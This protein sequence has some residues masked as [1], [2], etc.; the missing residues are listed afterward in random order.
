MFLKSVEIFGFKSFAD[1]MTIDFRTGISAILGPNGCGKSNIVDAIKWVLG[2][3]RSKDVRAEKKEDVIFNGTETRKR[4]NVAEVTL[5]ISNEANLLPIDISEIS[6]KR[7]IYRSGENE[8][9]INGVLSRQRDVR[10]LF[11]DT[12]IGKSAYSILEQGKIDQVLSNKPEER[13]YLFEEA[14]GISKFKIKRLEA[15]RKLERT[16]ENIKQVDG[17]INEVKKSHDNLLKQAEKASQYRE[18]KE[19]I[20]NLELDLQLI[21]LKALLADKEDK[22][23]ALDSKLEEQ[24]TI[25]GQ[26]KELD[27]LRNQG[28]G[29]V[30]DMELSLSE[31][32]KQIFGL[33]VEKEATDQQIQIVKE[34]KISIE[35]QLAQK[36]HKDETFQAKLEEIREQIKE[37]EWILDEYE[38]KLKDFNQNI[39]EFQDN[40]EVSEE[41]IEDNRY[42]MADLNRRIRES[43]TMYSELTSELRQITDEI[44][45]QLDS[46]L[47]SAGYSKT[48]KEQSEETIKQVLN[49]I[50]T[51]LNNKNHLLN[52]FL[53][54]KDVSQDKSN[55]F[56]ADFKTILSEFSDNITSLKSA[57]N[58][59]V[60]IF[61]DFIDEFL[62]PE[63][64]ITKKR[65]ID[66]KMETLLETIDE[67]TV[68]IAEIEEENH[69][70]TL[71]VREY[72]NTLEELKTNSSQMRTQ[73]AGFSEQLKMLLQQKAAQ[74][75]D[76][77][78]NKKEIDEF[79]NKVDSLTEHI[80]TLVD[81][82][83][84]ICEKEES[85]KDQLDSVRAEIEKENSQISKNEQRLINLNLNSD[86]V[87]A[88]LEKLQMN[89]VSI[90][91]DIQNIYNN[92]REKHSR[93]LTEFIDKIDE[94]TATNEELR[95]ALASNREEL[96]G[97]G[98]VNLMAPQEYKEVKERYDFLNSQ[99]EDLT[100]ARDNLKEITD[101]IEKES[102][103]LFVETYELIRKNFNIVFRRLF[104]GG[105]AEIILLDEEDVLNSG[106][107]IYAQPPGKSLE[108]I[109]L[110][111]GGERSMTAVAL[112]FA[113]YM[114]R[115]APFCIL[116]EID[117]ALDERNIMRFTTMLQEFSKGSQFILITHNKKTVTSAQTLIGVTMQESG[118]SKII[119]I[120]LEGE[121]GTDEQKEEEFQEA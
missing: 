78:Q 36:I 60:A 6:I 58:N 75:L 66:E 96:R 103:E 105:K 55:K 10:D 64:I 11:L 118:I 25:K 57:F 86:K 99:I 56:L 50:E 23:L 98:S 59:Y 32:Q 68:R 81:R 22:D 37:K 77:E 108:S 61:P 114:V 12:G 2:S 80:F 65:T 3:S 102:T 45:V 97:L 29:Q 90:N 121:G 49:T 112:L 21:R 42:D 92:F 85:F 5:V 31:M 8:Y 107:E 17:I 104:G 41:K 119:S 62:A 101:R 28:M 109:S 39:E 34:Q 113:T 51:S 72:R 43:Q 111:S 24:K 79:Q 69:T 16:E 106:I 54:L 84:E 38:S 14:A 116:D 74:K 44:V 82:R 88:Q 110:L 73:K 100:T 95:T 70:L 7:R 15:E 71:R 4:L 27:S 53:N 40:I 93:D 13:R 33:N 83:N 46:G 87:Q 76:A 117:A 120:K 26:I 47:N 35:E 52:D 63:G 19:E 1:K 48:Q 20:F 30:H 94:I 18:L 9:F 115:P 89:L 91:S 67:A